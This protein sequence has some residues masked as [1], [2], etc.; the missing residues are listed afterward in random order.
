MKKFKIAIDFY[1]IRNR[2][3]GVGEVS[4]KLA[5]ALSG[6]APELLVRGVEFYYIVPSNYV[7]CFGDDVKYIK[8]NKFRRLF[9]R[10]GFKYYDIFHAV[11]QFGL[12]KFIRRASRTILTLHDVNFMYEKRGAKQERYKKKMGGRIKSAD[13]IVLISEFVSDDVKRFYPEIEYKSSVIYN[14]VTDLTSI[15]CTSK[16]EFLDSGYL[17]HISSLQPKKNPELLI[18]MMQYLP[19]ERLIMVGNWGSAYGYSLKGV[20]KELG[21]NNVVTMQHV[22]NETKALLYANCKAFLFPSLCE[23]FGLPPL[24]AMKFGKP[25]FLSD[26]TS[27]PEVGGECAY[28][29]SQLKPDIMADVFYVGM[30]DWERNGSSGAVEEWSRRFTWER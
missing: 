23:G 16:T 15:A 13:E 19:N 1:S 24:E 11:H 27:L 5:E 12:I 2:N 29:W 30:K 9:I 10:Y 18:R 25:V 7:G 22:D 26:L 28:Y 6:F 17:L 21:L 8:G 3:V 14:G 20:I 4:Y